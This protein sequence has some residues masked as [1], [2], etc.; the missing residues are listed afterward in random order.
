MGSRGYFEIRKNEMKQDKTKIY[1][2]NI[3]MALNLKRLIAPLC[4]LLLSSGFSAFAK[5]PQE[6]VNE[7]VNSASVSAGSTAVMV[8]DL[9]DGRIL[10]SYN[11]STPLIPASIMKSITI[12]SLS[13]TVD[14]DKPIITKCYIDGKVDSDGVLN[15]NIIV[16]G[17][18]D[19]SINSKVWP[20]GEDFVK[21]IAD[22]LKNM[23]VKRIMGKVKVEQDY[24]KGPAV[25][26][27]WAS[28]DLS[29]SYGTGSHAFNFANNASGK[30]SV[31]DPSAVFIAQLKRQLSAVGIS[32][33]DGTPATGGRKLLLE[34]K[35]PALKEIMRSCMMRSDNLYAESM[36]RRYGKEKG[37]DG[38]TSDAATREMEMWKKKGADM[39]G[40]LIADGS[41]LSRSNRVTARFMEDVLREKAN[42]VEYVSFFPLAG[43]EGT[44]R[45]LLKDTDLDSYIAMKTGSMNGVQCYAGYKLDDDFAPT[46]V[47]VII[48]NNF[49]GSR[50][51]LR[52]GVE[53]MLLEIFN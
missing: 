8:S 6:A 25:H 34:H 46:H 24:F 18:G 11:A 38:S 37:G 43:Q 49:K 2:K 1:R 21:E 45:S 15:G 36:L 29:Q 28:G 16:E 35:S 39:E 5:S 26:P 44:L 50:A 27:S 48:I 9:K 33:E 3:S 40:V 23:G 51:D 19:P 31:K 10:A 47:V 20:V 17:A 22:A 13:E 30:A 52:K 41:G 42:D 7:F 32:I 4:V 12:A 53:K 14:V